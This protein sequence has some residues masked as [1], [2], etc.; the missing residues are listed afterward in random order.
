VARRLTEGGRYIAVLHLGTWSGP[1]MQAA[2]RHF[3]GVFPTAQLWLPPSGAD[4]LILIGGDTQPSLAALLERGGELPSGLRALELPTAPLLSGLAVGDRSSMLRWVGGAE[5]RTQPQPRLFPAPLLHLASFAP[6]VARPSE[7]WEL[8]GAETQQAALQQRLEGR[9]IFLQLL[10]RA[11]AGD[12]QAVFSAS[13]ALLAASP[14]PAEASAAL[15]AL[16][17]PQMITGAQALERARREGRGSPAWEEA[18]RLATTA[19]MFSPRSPGPLLLLG[20]IALASGNLSQAR[21]S[22]SAAAALDPQLAEAGWGLA[23]VARA[24][25][26]PASAQ[27]ALEKVSRDH[28]ADWRAWQNLGVFFLEQGRRAEAEA[29]LEK[30]S[31]LSEGRQPAPAQAMAELWLEASQ[32]SR[33]LPYAERAVVVGGSAYARFLR[34]RAFFDLGQLDLAEADFRAAVIEDPRLLEAR[35][36]IGQIRA[37]QGDLDAAAEAFRAVLAVDPTNIAARENLNRA[38]AARQQGASPPL[39][40]PGKP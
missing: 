37:I 15:D 38:E 3:A 22:Y 25:Q 17:E 4:S 13:Q 27:E 34:G 8:S 29:A 20:E 40:P 9:R 24:R 14:D 5:P 28:P 30:A 7:I 16:I 26:D 2:L 21:D 35:G 11:S 33:A 39:P 10:E 19:R 36:A 32:P 18:S 12:M 1:D 6:F 23:R 31:A